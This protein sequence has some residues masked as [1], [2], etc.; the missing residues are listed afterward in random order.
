[1]KIY[2]IVSLIW[3]HG[4]P[5]QWVLKDSFPDTDE[6]LTQCGHTAQHWLDGEARLLLAREHA[7]GMDIAATYACLDEVNYRYQVSK[8]R[9]KTVGPVE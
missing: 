1:V 9:V 7:R 4:V 3:L 6:G 2:L 8:G 5:S